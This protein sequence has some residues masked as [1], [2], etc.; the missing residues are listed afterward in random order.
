MNLTVIHVFV[1]FHNCYC[2]IN[3]LILLLNQ[4]VP[5]EQKNNHVWQN[6]IRWND[7]MK[8]ICVRRSVEP[9]K[10]SMHT[11]NSWITLAVGD[12][13]TVDPESLSKIGASKN[14]IRAPSWVWLGVTLVYMAKIYTR[15]CHHPCWQGSVYMELAQVES[16]TFFPSRQNQYWVIL[17]WGE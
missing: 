10:A 5:F 9:V 16:T 6:Q 1:T 17:F 7:V 3:L 13:S 8:G 4:A 15:W 12:S 14:S 2:D 11:A